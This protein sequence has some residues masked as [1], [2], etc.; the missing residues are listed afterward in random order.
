MKIVKS[1]EQIKTLRGDVMTDLT[2]HDDN[3]KTGD[4]CPSSEHN[5]ILAPIDRPC[6]RCGESCS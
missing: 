6:S 3:D 1:E 5:D 2:S 4:F